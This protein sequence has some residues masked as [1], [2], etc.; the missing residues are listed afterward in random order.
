LTGTVVDKQLAI[1]GARPSS[2]SLSPRQMRPIFPVETAPVMYGK[3]L[4]KKIT[5]PRCLS[6]IFFIPTFQKHIQ[7]KEEDFARK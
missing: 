6:R 1:D 3:Y 4:I 2:F 7:Y 5:L